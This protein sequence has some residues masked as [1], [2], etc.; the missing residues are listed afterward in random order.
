MIVTALPVLAIF[1]GLAVLGWGDLAGFFAHPARAG[2]VVATLL[3]VILPLLSDVSLSSGTRED[4][5]NRWMFVPLALV[6]LAFAYLPPQSFL[7][8][9]SRSTRSALPPRIFLTRSSP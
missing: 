2:L 7:P 3:L 6:S 9:P 8:Q 4:V 5:R 1:F